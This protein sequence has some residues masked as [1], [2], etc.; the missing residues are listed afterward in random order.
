MRCVRRWD[1]VALMINCIIGAG[2][3]G[4]PSQIHALSGMYS[5][6]AFGICGLVVALVAICY[7]EVS[8]RFSETGGPYLYTRKA[9]GPVIG[10]QIGWVTWLARLCS[11]AFVCNVLVSYLSYFWTPAGSGLWRAVL[12]TSVVASL[13]IINILGVSKAAVASDILSVA[14]LIPL[15]LFVGAG[16]IFINPQN[17]SIAGPPALGS[18]SLAVSQLFV[19]FTGFELGSIAAG[20]VRDPQ[21]NM[22]FG[23]LTALGLV[24]LLY[25]LI[26]VVCIGTLPNL[27]A[28]EKPLSDA[29][30]LFLGAAGAS[31]IT[32]GALISCTG[33][34][35]AILLGGSRLPFA[36]AEQNQLPGILSSTDQHFRTPSASILLT[37]LIGL[38][39]AVSGTF[40]YAITLAAISKLLTSIATCA[41]LP[42]LRRQ[43]GGRAATF[44]APAGIVLSFVAVGVCIWL[45]GNSGW[46]ELR[47]VG[48][49]IG[50]GLLLHLVYDQKRRRLHSGNEGTPAS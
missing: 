16:L 31:I 15:L 3:F 22:P 7:A 25:M 4:L 11:M 29:S 20:E 6:F 45:L 2:I 28:S 19:A 34:L 21:R 24:V 13:T 17:Y 18:F 50:I 27:A 43:S 1:V 8:S 9:F 39:L 42:V 37:A 46:R 48:I 49:A 40:V 10:F 5:L 47:D 14:K 41:A 35:N 30:S 26:Q 32:L 33:T 38:V 44:K 23:I 36:M 12:M